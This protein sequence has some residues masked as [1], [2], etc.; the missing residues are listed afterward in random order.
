MVERQFPWAATLV[1]MG[2]AVSLAHDDAPRKHDP[3]VP[4]SAYEERSVEGWTVHVNRRLLNEEAELGAKALRLLEVKLYDITRVVPSKALEELRKV[5]IWLGVDDGPAP[6][7]EYHPS[8]QWLVDNGWN[9]DKARCVEI[10][11]AA[12]F[13]DW[14]KDQPAMILHELAHSYHDRVLGFDDPDVLAA[15]RKA[16]DAKLYDAVLHNNGRETRSYA[17]TDHKEYFAEGSEA[18]FATNDMFPFVHAE[19]RRHDSELER[20]LGDVWN[21]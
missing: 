4:T 7:A 12:R 1:L 11:N 15:F 19:L 14:S 3:F 10:G 9:P 5:P 8:K 6:C 13:L 17:M 2:A 16:R 18:F 20:V 21:R